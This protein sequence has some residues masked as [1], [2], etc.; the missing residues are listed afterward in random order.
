MGIRIRRRRGAEGAPGPRLVLV[1][2]LSNCQSQSGTLDARNVCGG[3]RKKR[4][5]RDR[6]TSENGSAYAAWRTNSS[7]GI[8]TQKHWNSRRRL[9]GRKSWRG[10]G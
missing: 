6:M 10:K 8:E 7:S 4:K 3:S 9:Y 5:R 1:G 2:C